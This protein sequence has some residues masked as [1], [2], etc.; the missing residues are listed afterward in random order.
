M[1][2]H[3]AST[4][5]NTYTSTYIHIQLHPVHMCNNSYADCELQ[6]SLT[7]TPVL[8]NA[9]RGCLRPCTTTERLRYMYSFYT[10]AVPATCTCIYAGG[11]TLTL[12]TC[13][14]HTTHRTANQSSHWCKFVPP[15][16][17]YT[18]AH[19]CTYVAS[20][21]HQRCVLK[22]PKVREDLYGALNF[23]LHPMPPVSSIPQSTVY[24]THPYYSM[25]QH[26]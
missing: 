5:V 22:L 7:S 25:L 20:C 1:Y 6:D 15:P 8:Y 23:Q 2:M 9:N 14:L 13:T 24:L 10:V 16:L 11:V 19:T 12:Q 3:N 4:V 26:G 17:S 18:C 21:T